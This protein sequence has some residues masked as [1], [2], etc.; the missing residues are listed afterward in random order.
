ML[1]TFKKLTFILHDRKQWRSQITQYSEN[2]YI[3][4]IEIM[5]AIAMLYQ[6]SILSKALT[7]IMTQT[8]VFGVWEKNEKILF[9]FKQFSD[10]YKVVQI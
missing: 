4:K 2:L 8:I 6:K 9:Q 10:K 1:N 5:L 7:A 3:C